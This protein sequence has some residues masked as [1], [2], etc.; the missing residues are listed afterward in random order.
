MEACEM[1]DDLRVAHIS[2]PP[3]QSARGRIVVGYQQDGTE[4]A[5]PVLV[6]NG[7]RQGPTVYMGA[8]IHGTEPS[9]AEVIRQIMRERVNASALA[10]RL[11]AIPIQNPL[12]FRTSTYHSLEDG[13]NGNRIFPGDPTE[14]LTNRLVAAISRYAVQ[15]SDYVFDLHC[16][17]RDSILFNFVRWNESKAGRES[18]AISRAFGFTTVLSE[19][20]RQGFG[21]E[22][23][24]VG[25]LADMAL[26]QGKPTLTVELTPT[27]DLVPH[28]IA[29]G[30]RGVLNVLRH[31][32]MIEGEL[33][34]QRDLP[35]I[36]EL[37]GPQLRVTP[38]RGGF[39]HP[40]VPIGTWVTKGQIVALIR[41]PW[42]DMVEEIA[43]PTDG[44]VLAYP[45]HG[46]HAVASGDIVAFV[47]PVHPPVD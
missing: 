27:Y 36:N 35:I 38:E 34:P 17:A 20:K 22:E 44:Y 11:I 9:G 41:D 32:K 21:F 10:G 33:E 29:G 25:L 46:N 2:C 26:A 3:G 14:T 40:Q 8:L 7:T 31:L 28:I 15:Q 5:L 30:V 45:H 19:A 43:S 6:L 12:A 37:L 13:L 4:L 23:R 16:N 39:V 47:A 24:L 42:G 18:V 1:T